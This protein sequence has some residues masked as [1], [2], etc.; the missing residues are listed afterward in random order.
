M[1]EINIVKRINIFEIN[2][3][4]FQF[5]TKKEFDNEFNFKLGKILGK[6]TFGIVKKCL[7]KKYK[8]YFA[9]KQIE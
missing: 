7:S 1:I 8:K 4:L 6:G 3:Y 5:K 9:I 2:N